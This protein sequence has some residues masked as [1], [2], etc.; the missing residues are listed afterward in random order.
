MDMEHVGAEINRIS[1]MKRRIAELRKYEMHI[2]SLGYR[3]KTN[4]SEPL[5]SDLLL[6]AI[7]EQIAREE[8]FIATKEEELAR[9]II[10]TMD[11]P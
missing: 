4:I 1:A 6:V 10:R 8:K 3:E 9:D 7:K 5:D 11:I 2:E